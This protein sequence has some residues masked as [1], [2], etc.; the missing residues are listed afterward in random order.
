MATKSTF[1]FAATCGT[2]SSNNDPGSS[3]GIFLDFLVIVGCE[4]RELLAYGSSATFVDFLAWAYVSANWS[5][6][7]NDMG[8][9]PAATG[10][11]SGAAG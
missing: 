7:S 10:A 4:K 9:S 3:L 6:Y 2:G 8:T 5:Y 11:P 1:G